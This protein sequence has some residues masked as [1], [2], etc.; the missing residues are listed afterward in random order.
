MKILPLAFALVVAVPLS[1]HAQSGAAGGAVGGAAVG[2]AAAGPAGAA[3]GAAAGAVAGGLS[4]ATRPRF[5][6]YVTR[7]RRPSYKW[8][9]S[10]R[11]G[12]VLPSSGVTYYDVPAEY[13]VSSYK[14]T[15]V[16]DRPV[17]VEPSSRRIVQVID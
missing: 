3:V 2:G 17:L 15:I 14:Y 11:V 1:A 13:G 8:G 10:V 6:E 7:E 16:D 4:D 9:E 5:R 12:A